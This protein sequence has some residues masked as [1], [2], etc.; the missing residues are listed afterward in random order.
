MSAK[1]RITI[2]L[3]PSEYAAL[4]R[5]SIGAERSLAW[6]GRKAIC[7]FIDQQERAEAP[8]LAGL[9]DTKEIGGRRT[10]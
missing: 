9:S 7:D 4:Q 8:L 1:F 6:L 5:L 10:Q 3:E 2:N